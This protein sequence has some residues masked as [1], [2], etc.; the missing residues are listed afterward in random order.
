VLFRSIDLTGVTWCWIALGSEGRGEQTLSSDQDNAL[1]FQSDLPAETVRDRLLPVAKRINN[2]L[3]DCGFPLCKG[4]IM[5]SNPMWCL[6]TEEWRA[7]FANWIQLG[8]G[9][10]LLHASIFFDFRA[11]YGE[12]GLCNEL[13]AWL[14]G[15][16]KQNRL[17]LK[18]MV[19]NALANRPPLGLVRDFVVSS[20]DDQA[21]TLDLKINGVT[22]F[23]DA[24]RIFALY[25]GID[26]PGTTERL[27]QV[28]L[29]WNMQL[30]EVEAWV[31]ALNYI[32]LLRLR[33]QYEDQQKGDM[34]TNRIDPKQLNNLDRRILKESFR[35]ARKLQ[36]LMGNYFEF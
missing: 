9:V 3:A 31:A 28:G 20:D 4:E 8:D 12:A 14:N 11:L 5:A 1:I 13:R 26:A 25:A 27:R 35:Q 21:N 22:P 33:H 18:R 6:S 23:V 2:A 16:I 34:P 29:S 30:S 32:Q 24:A 15:V 17:F 10:A 7:T 19:E 36:S